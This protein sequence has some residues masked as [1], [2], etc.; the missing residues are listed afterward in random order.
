MVNWLSRVVCVCIVCCLLL[1]DFSVEQQENI[2]VLGEERIALIELRSSLGIRAKEWPIKKNPCT[3][4]VGVSCSPSNS[5]VVEIN[6][7][8]FTR[9]IKGS[10]NP[11]F[12]VDA[13]QNLTALEA[14]NASNFALHGNF[15]DWFGLS[16]TSLQV[17]D[18]SSCGIAGTIPSTFGNFINLTSL[19]LSDNNLAGSIPLSLGQLSRLSVLD[20][21]KNSLS[22]DIPES[23]SSLGNLSS[24]DMSL[25]S[26]SGEI[27]PGIG[28]LSLLKRLNLSGNSLSS[29]I[30]FQLGD[31]SNLVDLDISKNSL[32]GPLPAN[33]FASMRQIRFLVMDHANF[34]G[35]F[36]EILWSLPQ[37]RF[38]DASGNNFTGRLPDVG[39]NVSFTGAII[40]LA[41]NMF[42]GNLT[43]VIRRF[44]FVDLSANYL[45]GTVPDYARVNVSLSSN[46][47]DNVPD[48]RNQRECSLFYSDRTPAISGKKNRNIMFWAVLGGVALSVLLV[49][50]VVVLCV[51]LHKKGATEQ[52]GTAE[53][54]APT[55]T[56]P[57]F[58]GVSLNFSI[59]GNSFDYL[60]ILQAT[61]EFN[62][63]NLIKHGHSGDLYTGL[64]EGEIPVVIKK[65]DFQSV[66]KEAYMVELD[67]FCKVP[68]HFR[69]VPLLGYCLE[70]DNEKF[71]VYK[72][73]PNGDLSSVLFRNTNADDEKLHSLDWITRLKIAIGAA[74]GLCYLHHDCTPPLVHRD[75]QA[76]SILLDDKFEVRL[77]SLSKVCVQEGDIHPRRFTRLLHMPQTSEQGT[78]GMC[79][80]VYLEVLLY[81]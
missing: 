41:S 40:N 65:V 8:R 57:Q 69:L 18:L 31:L 56:N 48:Q 76:S 23:F 72:Y 47:L 16:F 29:S 26:L 15:P 14:F 46:C 3:D 38:L 50:F 17:L 59:L 81:G 61:G 67:N 1:F 73:M 21:S 53:E 51:C 13:M 70:K 64:L 25:N 78:S 54:P 9:T 27:P 2:L 42:F 52:R 35:E 63:K 49:I 10:Q 58:P 30:P 33:F 11:L 22:G 19:Y 7:S 6:I 66:K 79:Q 74:E 34:S 20:L 55:R 5:R 4:W 71:L 77:G 32:V 43:T 75:V 45:Q 37:L 28:K 62:N 36:P 44:S 24:L 68:S 80:S 60:Q 39:P 12:S